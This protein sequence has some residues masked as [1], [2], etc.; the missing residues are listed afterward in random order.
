MPRARQAPAQT[1]THMQ[2]NVRPLRGPGEL[3]APEMPSLPSGPEA[4]PGAPQ[5]PGPAPVAG[6]TPGSLGGLL[7]PTGLPD[8]PIT[9]GLNGGPGP[10][11]EA[12]G[13]FGP[14]A[15]TP[16]MEELAKYLPTLELLSMQPG[17]SQKVRNMVRLIKSSMNPELIAQPPIT[18][19]TPVERGADV[20]A[21]DPGLEAMPAP[22]VE[23]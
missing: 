12:L 2:G 6:P 22:M 8:E 16:D 21:Q 4:G 11:E 23:A 18:D 9:A 5:S 20:A 13:A 1:S 3:P 19:D 17:T 15:P 7:D 10:G 14:Q